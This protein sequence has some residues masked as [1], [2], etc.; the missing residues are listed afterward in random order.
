MVRSNLF[1]LTQHEHDLLINT[2]MTSHKVFKAR[3]KH[4]AQCVALKFIS[5]HGK[6]QSDVASLRQEIAILTTVQHESIIMMFDAF[7]T[8]RDFVVATEFARGELFQV[9]KCVLSLSAYVLSVFSHEENCRP[10]SLV[11]LFINTFVTGIT[12]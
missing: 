1:K 2:E 11:L 8:E 6:K 3:K 5:K 7:E 12:R 10:E 9:F 4:S